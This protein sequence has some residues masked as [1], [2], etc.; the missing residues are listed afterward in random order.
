MSKLLVTISP[1]T[2]NGDLHIGHLAGP[3]LSA[4]VYTRAQRQRG[5]EAI[6]VSYSDDY[7]SYMLRKGVELDADP[8]ELANSYTDKICET[9]KIMDIDIDN[10]LRPY[11]NPF[12]KDAVTEVYNAATAADLIINKPSLEP[13]CSG[14]DRW[15]Y[16][17][18]GR[19][20]C[21]Y[22][23]VDSDASQCE[24]CGQE[25]IAKEMKNFHCKLCGEAHEWVEVKRDFLLL[26]KCEETLR[27]LYSRKVIRLPLKS[28]IKYTLTNYLKEWGVTRPGDGGLDLASDGSRRIH[29]WFMGLS[30]YLA[31]L[32]EY[33]HEANT[34]ELYDDILKSS[35]SRFIHFMGFDCALSHNI[36]YP[37]LLSSIPEYEIKQLFYP[38]QFL[39]LNGLNLSTS[40]N[41][42]IWGR[43]IATNYESDPVRLYLASISPEE[44]ESDFVMDVFNVWHDD[45]YAKFSENLFKLSSSESTEF[46]GQ[47]KKDDYEVISGLRKRWLSATSVDQFSMCD[48]AQ[49]T[50]DTMAQ[51]EQ[52]LVRKVPAKYLIE[53]LSV[54]CKPITPKLADRICSF[55]KIDEDEVTKYL[56]NG[57]NEAEYSI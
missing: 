54:F 47:L 31:A 2:P 38:N 36:I 34:P 33:A 16:E 42:V 17:A 32:K 5:H 44:T 3:F 45:V 6:L 49:I 51:I 24:G 41:H 1:P 50:L 30:G 29:T 56:I 53:L 11:E 15:G 40:R 20:D 21:N 52:R 23:G 19:G 48:L 43:D 12:F 37:S 22:C 39:K 4:D 55:F 8:M 26:E 46:L 57:L 10:W 14:C 28:W 27:T 18:F 35:D 9:L 13:Y 7:Q 25:P